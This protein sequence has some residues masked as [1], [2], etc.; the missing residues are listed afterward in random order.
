MSQES[1]QSSY[2][3]IHFGKEATS[4]SKERGQWLLANVDQNIG[5]TQQRVMVVYRGRKILLLPATKT[6]H[7]AAAIITKDHTLKEGKTSLMQF[8]SALAWAEQ[9]KIDIVQW[10]NSSTQGDLTKHLRL[11][12]V[13]QAGMTHLFFR[14]TELPNP[15]DPKAQLALAL[16]REGTSLTHPGYSFLSY[17]KIINLKYRNG[18]KQTAWL[19]RSLPL[20]ESLHHLKERFKKLKIQHADPAAYIYESCRCAVAHASMNESTYDP[21]NIEDELRFYEM[22]PIVHALAKLMIEKEFGVKAKFT[23]LGGMPAYV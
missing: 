16:F 1:Q 2:I 5:W 7:A 6:L 23:I 12:L 21:E 19:R 4:F 3:P 17:Y 22:G 13:K 11:P 20:I 14:P 9:G 10:T 8:L 18:E 15:S